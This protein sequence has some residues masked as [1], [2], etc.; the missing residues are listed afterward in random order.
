VQC[1]IKNHN[2]K[3]RIMLKKIMDLMMICQPGGIFQV[4]AQIRRAII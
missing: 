2:Q 1:E 3:D 4:L